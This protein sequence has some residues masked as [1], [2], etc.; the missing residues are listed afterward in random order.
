MVS[1][2]LTDVDT[3]LKP[4]T[5]FFLPSLLAHVRAA[6]PGLPLEPVIIQVLLL[7]IA[8]GDR[9]LIL[10]TR[11]DDIDLVAKLTTLVLGSVLGYNVHKIK[12][13]AD[14]SDRTPFQILRS[15]FLPAA[16]A[17]GA[18]S[19]RRNRERH[20]RTSSSRNSNGKQ[21][22]MTQAA[23]NLGH[24][25]TNSFSRSASYPG[26][27]W[28]STSA[29]QQRSPDSEPHNI[30]AVP[31]ANLKRP[32]LHSFSVQTE[33]SVPTIVSDGRLYLGKSFHASTDNFR[34]PAAV[35][36][37]G[38]EHANLQSQKAILR[39]LAVR[40]LVFPLDKTSETDQVFN[41][42]ENFILI[43][44]CRLDARERPPIYK[45]LLDRFAMSSP[46]S[47]GQQTRLAMRQFRLSSTQSSAL[48][49][50]STSGASAA[51]FVTPTAPSSLPATLPGVPL[52]SSSFLRRL[53]DLCAH[54]TYVGAQLG[55]YLADLFTATR[56]FGSLDGTLL[57]VRARKDAE[58]LVRA[59]RVLGIDLTGAEFI[60]EAIHTVPPASETSS[61]QRSYPASHS[62][63]SLS[64]EALLD[65]ADVPRIREPS[66]ATSVERNPA[67]IFMQDDV[68]DLDVS[69]ADIARI[70][71]RVVSHRV[72]VRDSPFDEVL[73]SVVC[74]DMFQPAGVRDGDPVW[75]R[76][77]VKDILIRILSEV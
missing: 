14:A 13:R 51:F 56:H 20:R 65:S 63:A 23:A 25:K 18:D 22:I 8:S 26:N 53:K 34:V 62:S 50:P 32:S 48:P 35:V 49:S 15:L 30:S 77:T 69:E 9:N 29:P 1:P 5:Q 17:A 3:L 76:D 33:Q 21:P 11:D 45:S 40:K 39:T 42:P 58:A 60:R 38:L 4:G 44:I 12:Y 68:S 43:Y 24:G 19:S 66:L 31:I 61:I 70:F 73:S 71:P 75:E 47:V 59:C 64:S 41:L 16:V 36:V 72:R 28:P 54:H 10:R 57:T 2:N 6:L 67:G 27:R 46:V 74:G 52:I 7:C 37:S 55:I